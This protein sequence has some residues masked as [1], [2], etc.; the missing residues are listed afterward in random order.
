MLPENTMENYIG[1]LLRNFQQCCFMNIIHSKKQMKS[2]I[3]DNK[4]VLLFTN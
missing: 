2:V 1:S 4:Y 3:V